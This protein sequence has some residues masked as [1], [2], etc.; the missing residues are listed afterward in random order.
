[1][2][3]YALSFFIFFMLHLAAPAQPFAV[4]V[5]LHIHTPISP[6]LEEW[7]SG[8]PS[9][10]RLVLVLRDDDEM[11]YEARLRFSISGQGISIRTRDDVAPPPLFLDYNL[12]LVLTGM[13]LLDYFS[14]EQLQFQG[15]SPATYLQQGGKLP[16]GVYNICVEVLDYVRFQGAAVSNQA[17][18]VVEM[19][20]LD[21]PL[22]ISPAE[23][24]APQALQNVLFQWVPQH[25]GAFPVDYRIR[26]W[27]RREGLSINQ[28][29]EQ[30]LPLYESQQLGATSLLYG[31]AAPA[32]SPGQQYLLQVQARDVFDQQHFK[33]Q[34]FSQVLVFTYGQAVNATT[35][36]SCSLAPRAYPPTALQATGFSARWQALDGVDHYALSLAQDSAF[37]LPLTEYQSISVSD[38]SYTFQGLA[39]EAVY[40]YRVQAIHADCA[41][42]FSNAIK[43]RLGNRCL[44]LGDHLPDYSCGNTL[45]NTDFQPGPLVEH[46][47]TGDTIRAH[48]FQV[49]LQ[50]VV[51]QGHFS[52]QGYV[53]VP[54]LHQ[55]RVNVQFEDIKVD[56]YCR[57]VEG[58]IEVTGA[59]LAL[60]SQDLAASID[61]IL[62]A[63]EVL[64]AGLTEAQ[65]ILEDAS[66]FL[67]GLEDI[68]AY[69][70]NGQSVL[71]NLLHLEQHFPYLSPAALEAIKAALD[72][73]KRAGSAADFEACKAQ[74]LAAIDQLK[75]AMITLYEADF[76]VNFGPLSPQQYGF[77][78]LQ[79]PDHEK[80]YQQLPIAQTD[81]WIAWQ[82]IPKQQTAQVKVWAPAQSSFPAN[83]LFKDELKQAIPTTASE[84][85]EARVLQLQGKSQEA[86]Q[87][88]YALAPYQGSLGH[89]QFHIAGQLNV[90]TYEPIKLKVV[91]VPVN[92]ASY[93]YELASLENQLQQIFGQ[94]I[95]EVDLA[96]HPGL[97]VP[98]F[99]GSMAD[100]PSGFLANYTDQMQLIRAR[101]KAQH[102]IAEDTYYLF[103]VPASDNPAKLGYMPKK[104][105]F[106]FLYKAALTSE[107]SYS[108][109]I[110]H[111]LA[112][113]AYHLDHPFDA[114]PNQQKG[115]TNNLMDYA[116]G[117]H[118]QQYQW[119]LIHHPQANWTLFDGDEEGEM[120]NNT[121]VEKASITY[122]IG[123]TDPPISDAYCF[124]TPSHHLIKFSKE[125]S[126]LVYD[127]AD[128]SPLNPFPRGSLI[129]FE[130]DHTTY[131]GVYGKETKQFL[132]YCK[133]ERF[134]ELKLDG[135]VMYSDLKAGDYFLSYDAFQIYTSGTA[136][137]EILED[138]KQK[139][140][141]WP[142]HSN[143]GLFPVPQAS[144]SSLNIPN[145]ATRLDL[146]TDPSCDLAINGCSPLSIPASAIPLDRECPLAKLIFDVP[147]QNL[148]EVQPRDP[149][150]DRVFDFT[151]SSQGFLTSDEVQ[152][153]LDELSTQQVVNGNYAL[154][155]IFLTD[156]TT[157][158]HQLIQAREGD[159][160]HNEW[161]L[162][163]HFL[164]Q[165]DKTYLIPQIRL[166]ND[167]NTIGSPYLLPAKMFTKFNQ[168]WFGKAP[169][170]PVLIG[171]FKTLSWGM[172]Q[173]AKL[174]SNDFQ[175]SEKYWKPVLD[176]GEENP[177]YDKKYALYFSHFLDIATLQNNSF[178]ILG[179]NL[180]SASLD[181]LE[182]IH[183][184]F[185]CGMWN[186]LMTEGAN[187]AQFV[188]MVVDFMFDETVCAQVLE[189]L[190]KLKWQDIINGLLP[191]YVPYLVNPKL[192]I[193]NSY[194]AG[195][196]M[197]ITLIF[198]IDLADAV[199]GA[200][201]LLT[202]FKKL[203]DISSSALI[204]SMVKVR[205][206]L[207]LRGLRDPDNPSFFIVC[208][209]AIG[210]GLGSTIDLPFQSPPI[211]QWANAAWHTTLFDLRFPEWMAQCDRSLFRLHQSTGKCHIE[212]SSINQHLPE[213]F[214]FV[215]DFD[216]NAANTEAL[217]NDINANELVIVKDKGN[218]QLWVL[219]RSF[220][221]MVKALKREF[222]I[223]SSLSAKLAR[224][225]D[226]H[227]LIETPDLR[228]AIKALEEK[229]T[230]FLEDLVKMNTLSSQHS[231]VDGVVRFFRERVSRV[232]AWEM[233]SDVNVPDI[234]RLNVDNLKNI[235][236]YL[237]KAA[238][239]KKQQNALLVYQK[240]DGTHF[241]TNA[242]SFPDLNTGLA[243]QKTFSYKFNDGP[244]AGSKDV[245]AKIGLTDDGYLVGN[246]VKSTGM[247]NAGV[248]K[249]TE[250]AM[251]MALKEFGDLGNV[252]GVKAQWVQNPNLYPDLPDN[253]SIN[254]IMFEE[255]LETM[256]S[257]EAVFQTITG[258]YANSRVFT[259][260]KEIKQLTEALDGVNGYEVIFELP[261]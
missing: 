261:K 118:L 46:L 241:M 140:V 111:E 245:Y 51:G 49:I 223:P 189:A 234:V 35:A 220:I 41:S 77:D 143:F 132:G 195:Q 66:V 167:L 30:T 232:R 16:E 257:S 85:A 114:F 249:V 201:A 115:S 24:V 147:L 98:E 34:G 243:N 231:A 20:E 117:T 221:E 138:C 253:K 155:K 7:V 228:S 222:N 1:M 52:G 71:D 109:T 202:A 233:M 126:K 37:L 181:E 169:T 227:H 75:A 50:A 237:E 36:N 244:N 208:A 38:T 5:Q 68:G 251:D 166:G 108:K 205:Q 31:A 104:K 21:P 209:T 47:Q 101:F 27:E 179:R 62:G 165:G 144:Y 32:L 193:Q 73:L 133:E 44:P 125:V 204:K 194:I 89:D 91:L 124:L 9:K 156:C 256:S 196:N 63:L 137:A 43:V 58:K 42:P 22:I 168:L 56:E 211:S 107:Q 200:G 186:Q 157:P 177:H 188:G 206:K 183:F 252:K 210:T 119:D 113:G 148:E 218:S 8:A 260:V 87:T 96:L 55:A 82:S 78:S 69:L 93:P 13:E 54:Y 229:Q 80:L 152:D 33:N 11:A 236:N 192:Q 67:A 2:K 12:P 191:N 159:L 128:D 15:I 3:K 123:I 235:D 25:V 259:K 40:F 18:V 19:A 242:S 4:D 151:R 86:T 171:L 106:G 207:N 120:Q 150:N 100:V 146:G 217:P 182:Q 70:A 246:I 10:L 94:A 163:L 29:L 72:C 110:A 26:L 103:L 161:A 139:R 240:A 48:D 170:G 129:Q 134:D 90:I 136:V 224:L 153:L 102:P 216:L 121:P 214:E 130:F 238:K 230:A 122:L 176:N 149:S 190:D 187:M 145:D 6:Y 95:V 178:L 116:L 81:Y 180:D 60:I 154:M 199:T 23:V 185:F 53:Q 39:E 197:M 258:A 79:Y 247:N 99:S 65:A 131:I 64:E 97:Q 213:D 255:A 14:P 203:K 105:P 215:D 84:Q 172:G 164:R 83:I 250:D 198:L 173:V 59:G 57:L 88:I 76:R 162:H 141:T 175:I 158:E 142:T 112:H 184:A 174:L 135:Q 219:T 239:F 225:D 212:P 61:S 92:G 160:K 45:D 254:L 248:A 127:I 226:A 74:T 28:I 17:C